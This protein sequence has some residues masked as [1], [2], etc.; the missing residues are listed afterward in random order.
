MFNNYGKSLKNISNMILVLGFLLKNCY[1]IC[2][3]EVYLLRTD[4]SFKKIY[5]SKNTIL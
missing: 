3:N 5:N 2:A 1:R 4:H